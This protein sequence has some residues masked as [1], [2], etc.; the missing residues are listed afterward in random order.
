MPVA[1]SFFE[2]T[3]TIDDVVHGSS[4]YRAKISVY[5]NSEQGVFVLLGDAGLQFIGKHASELVESYYE[6]NEEQGVDHVVPVPQDLINAIGQTHRFIVKVSKRNFTDNTRDIT[7]TDIISK[8]APPSLTTSA[9]NPH[10][11]SF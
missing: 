10:C 9:E 1:G 3:A 2:C 8:E 4:W 5:D 6:T 11:S 7:V